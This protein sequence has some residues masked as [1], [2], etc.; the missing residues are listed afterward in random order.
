MGQ[1]LK[2]RVVLAVGALLL[3]AALSPSARAEDGYDLWLR[4]RP[5]AAERREAV[6]RM[7]AAIVSPAQVSATMSA[8]VTE[9]Q[10]GIAGLT[11][12][13]VPITSAAMDG[14]LVIGT[15]RASPLIAGLALPLAPLAHDGYL[16][17]T[18]VLDDRRVTVIAANE[19]IGVLYGAFAWLRLAQ[20][21]SGLADLDV[22]SSPRIGLRLLEHWDNLDGSVERGYA[23]ASLWDWW[24][25]PDYLEPRY[26]DYARAN[27]SIG[28]NGAVLNNVNAQAEIL[29]APYL[30]KVA[31]LASVFRPYGIRVYLSVRFSAPIDI[32]GLATADPLDETVAAWWQAKA[33]EIYARIPDFGGFLV[34]AD[35]EGQPGPQGYGR[36]HA[37]GANML[38]AA[39][40]P[41]GGVVFWRAFVYARNSAEDR[42]KQAYQEF[43]PLDGAFA[44]NVILQV[45]NGPLDFQPR[46]PFHPL[47]GAMPRTPL[48]LELQIT[49]EY[50]GF[51]THLA[52]LGVLFEEVLD[53][54]TYAQGAGSTVAHIVDGGLFA[55]ARTG[56]AGVANVGA[57]RDWTGAPFAQANW[58]AFGRLAWNP[59]LSAR[60]I[61]VEWLAMTF[62]SDSKFIDT[63]LAIMLR[64]REAVVDYMTPLGLA[65]LMGTGHHYG[66]APWVDDLERAEWTPYYYHRAA[67]DGIGFDRTASGSNAVAQYASP[68]ASRFA[69]LATVPEE[70]LLWFHRVPW[71]QPLRSGQTL[72]EELVR[73]YDRGVAEVA[74]MQADWATL[75]PFVDAERFAK[76]AELL[77]IQAREA[78]WWRDACLAYFSARSG[79]SLPRGVAQPEH[80]L[81]Y[82]MSLRFPYA[83]G[84]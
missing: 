48:A 12:R 28:I 43:V 2:C 27:A 29:T 76:T 6:T 46:E 73:H 82:Y 63:A 68:A 32:G 11:A 7:A 61:A 67:A 69:D 41:Y 79:L 57:A 78:R 65:H 25:L 45:K 33:D 62:T 23:G 8:A 16:I 80:S 19:D 22:V 30:G 38:A 59:E 20:T 5:L 39:L 51:A 31:A 74:A 36:T 14:A 54:D 3:A 9:L 56:I 71:D 52:Y 72:W 53:A 42:V 40:R 13:K 70:Y 60:E 1:D 83:P 64:S 47:F 10:T 84:R 34:K 17:R 35:S 15:P 18:L 81:E 75:A 55:Y 26:V 21:G 24:R 37:D 49:Q 77:E 4:Y 44:E 50:L 58:Y 66:P